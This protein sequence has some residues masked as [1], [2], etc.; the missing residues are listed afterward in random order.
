MLLSWKGTRS[1]TRRLRSLG[2]RERRFKLNV[3]Y[4]V[5][6]TIV[7]QH[8]QAFICL[9]NLTGIRDRSIRRKRKW[10]GQKI[11]PQTPKQRRANRHVS[12]WAFAKLHGMIMH[13]AALAGSVAIKV[14]A[15][16]TSQACPLCG[17]TDAKNRPGHGLLFLCQDKLCPYRLRTGRPYTLHADLMAERNVIM[18]TLLVRHDCT[19]K[20]LSS[21][22]E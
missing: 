22:L 13:R 16:Y 3:N 1:A 9:E 15:D 7:E 8:P 2:G 6:K 14:D 17:Y 18:R 5:A 12:T 20:S 4:V 11:L 10:K 19:R 21:A